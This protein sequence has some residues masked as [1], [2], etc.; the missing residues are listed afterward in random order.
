ML[1]AEDRKT[2]RRVVPTT[3]GSLGDLHPY[4]ALAFGSKEKGHDPIIATMDLYRERVE[5]AGLTFRPVRALQ[6][7][8][9]DQGL[10]K[11]VMDQE[12]GTEFIVRSLLMPALRVACEDTAAAAEDCDLLVAHPMSLATRLVAESQGIP[13]VST[14]L[15]PMVFFSP[16]DPP[17]L[18]PAPFVTKLRSLGPALYRPL[19]RLLKRTARSWSEPSHRL[20]IELGLPP[21]ADPLFEGMQ[22]PLLVL[23]L[24]SKRVERPTGVTSERCGPS[25]RHRETMP[26][27]LPP[28]SRPAIGRIC[29]A[30]S[31][32]HRGRSRLP[33]PHPR[34]APPS[35]HRHRARR[36]RPSAADRHVPARP[37]GVIHPAPAAPAGGARDRRPDGGPIRGHC[38]L[39]RRPPRVLDRSAGHAPAVVLGQ[40]L[41]HPGRAGLGIESR[42]S[43]RDC[44]AGDRSLE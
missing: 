23:A 38:L 8:R 25:R 2:R 35:L 5:A 12:T 40:A 9:P 24:F 21:A 10:M 30:S 42:P 36:P 20:R 26:V 39:R 6:G 33:P 44:P 28:E 34:A 17:V 3:F 11:R 43:L 31:A 1:R 13:W 37:P 29:Q 22:S 16:Y 19:F 14:Q 27:D 15:V 4:I 7:E 41:D 18:A 32:R